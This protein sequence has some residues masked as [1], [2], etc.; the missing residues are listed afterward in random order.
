MSE[1]D[2]FWQII[3][4]I[5]DIFPSLDVFQRGQWLRLALSYELVYQMTCM[6]VVSEKY[7]K[8]N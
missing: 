7:F 1:I 6:K 3:C 8:K 5:S 4:S 2:T